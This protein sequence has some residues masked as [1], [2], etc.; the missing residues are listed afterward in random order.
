MA[1]GGF[2]LPNV[3]G[4]SKQHTGSFRAGWICYAARLSAFDRHARGRAP[5]DK[6]L[7]WQR[8]KGVGVA[9]TSP[10][11]NGSGLK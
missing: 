2:V 4:F 11:G 6:N 10:S 8:R 3:L 1:L 5:M 7:G 9:V